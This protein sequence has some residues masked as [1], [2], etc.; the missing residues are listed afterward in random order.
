MWSAYRDAEI[1]VGDVVVDLS[2]TTSLQVTGVASKRAGEHPKVRS[3]RT[4]DLFGVDEDELV[5]HCVFLPDGDDAIS[6]PSK[7][8]AYPASRLLRYPVEEATPNERL[9]R[10]WLTNVL[11]E[12]AV[13]ANELGAQQRICLRE[14]VSNAFGSEVAGLL[15]EFVE[16]AGGEA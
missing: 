1:G 4:A 12:L 16:A 6:P 9:Q 3:D 11:E 14:V 10:E 15:E 2:R 5:Y 8:Y 13:E 7:T